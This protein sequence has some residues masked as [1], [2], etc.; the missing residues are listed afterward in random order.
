[1][2]SHESNGSSYLFF[3]KFTSL[4]DPIRGPRRQISYLDRFQNRIDT[5]ITHLS[6][7][8]RTGNTIYL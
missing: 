1:M 8:I 7:L 4:S 5:I 2:R 3:A 6:C